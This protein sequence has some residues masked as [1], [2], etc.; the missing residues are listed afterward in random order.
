MFKS[1][2]LL[3]AMGAALSSA[4]PAAAQVASA[5][6]RPA[7]TPTGAAPTSVEARA[8]A[9][10]TNM[11][12]ALALTPAQVEKVRAI[13][14]TAV[15]SVETARVRYRQD[16]AKLKGYID[17]IGLARLDRLK[18]VLTSV[19]FARYQQKREEKMGIPTIRGNQGNPPPGL[20]SR[21]DE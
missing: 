18:D 4:R 1:L 19:Q 5:A 11:T 12:Q 20:P 8:E 9:L 2:V 7:S 13:N 10:T 3:T 21:G 17:D 15:R 16:P 6:A 14:L